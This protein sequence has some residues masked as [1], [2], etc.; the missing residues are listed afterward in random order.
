[1]KLKSAVGSVIA[2]ALCAAVA[3]QAQAQPRSSGGTPWAARSANGSTEIAE[4]FNMSQS[5]YKMVPVYKGSY[6][7]TMTAGIAAFRAGKP[8]HILQVF[9][10]GMATL[11]GARG[12]IKPV[13]EL[14]DEAGA[15][16]SE[17]DYISAVTSYYTTTDGST[18]RRRCCGGTRMPSA[19][20]VST[21]KCHPRRGPKWA[22][23]PRS[24]RCRFPVRVLDG[25]DHVGP[26]GE[27]LRLA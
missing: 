8:P 9:E 18:A 27:L 15:T 19:R 1:M 25:L 26:L 13:H 16:F 10:V 2:A 11:M 12:A 5:D 7:E 6:G 21:R 20:P 3:G 17:D 4:N 22:N 24:C 23:S 14:M